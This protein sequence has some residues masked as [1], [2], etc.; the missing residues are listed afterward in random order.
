MKKLIV[1]TTA[2][3]MLASSAQ[4]LTIPSGHVLTSDGSVVHVTETENTRR[5]LDNGDGVIIA[6]G[7]VVIDINGEIISVPVNEVR[8]KTREQ[9]AEV[10]GEA[11]VAQMEDLHAAAEKH[12]QEIINSGGVETA[13]NAV[14][15]SIDEILNEIDLDAATGAVVG[16]TEEQNRN[17]C[18]AMGDCFH[19]DQVGNEAAHGG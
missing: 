14:G 5:A 8:G 6:G 17:L 9:V 11:I 18:D 4:A 12:V 16:I 7:M 2:L 1:T 19:P 3:I 15:K 13:V 10:L